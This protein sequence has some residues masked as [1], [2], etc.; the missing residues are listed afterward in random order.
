MRMHR[1]TPVVP[2]SDLDRQIKFY[3]GIFGFEVRL[4]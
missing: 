3:R 2:C 4:V 1:I